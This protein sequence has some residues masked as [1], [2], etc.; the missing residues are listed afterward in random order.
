MVRAIYAK[1]ENLSRFNEEWYAAINREITVLR[2]GGGA[3]C[4]FFL[5]DDSNARP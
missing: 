5:F 1:Q 3:E 2:R 4:L